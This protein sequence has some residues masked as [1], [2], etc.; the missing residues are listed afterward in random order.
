MRAPAAD[1]PYEAPAATGP[2]LADV[3]DFRAHL[4]TERR[5]AALTCENYSRDLQQLADWCA[6]QRLTAWSQLKGAHLRQFVAWRH[7]TGLGGRSIQRLLSATRTF[8]D[9]LLREGRATDN[10]SLGI[11]APKSPRKLPA[12][13]DPDAVAQLL[14]GAPLD[15]NPVLAARDRA[16]FELMY[17]SGLRLAELVGLDIDDIDLRASEVVVT[18]P[19]AP[20]I[21][22]VDD[23]SGKDVYARKDSSAWESLA[24]L[25][26]KLKAKGRPPVAIREVPGNLEDDDLLDMELMAKAFRMG[27]KTLEVPLPGFRRHG[28]RSSTTLSSAWNMY[29]GVWRLRGRLAGCTP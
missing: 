11:R 15:D 1:S 16:M 14:D 17:S 23:L 28:G 8:Y 19:G 25:N 21:A 5:L 7:R 27:V 4:A 18:G 20:R 9:F 10:P 24:T 29:A 2:L 22:S 12:V 13:L 26:G 3:A 6:R